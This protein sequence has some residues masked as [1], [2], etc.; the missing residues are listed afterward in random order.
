MS[1]QQE[2]KDGLHVSKHLSFEHGF[3]ETLSSNAQ[4]LQWALDEVNIQQFVR[5]LAIETKPGRTRNCIECQ[6]M[7]LFEEVG[8]GKVRNGNA[9]LKLQ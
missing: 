7:H 3:F 9:P 8:C 6:R 2:R 1:L 5:F 4:A